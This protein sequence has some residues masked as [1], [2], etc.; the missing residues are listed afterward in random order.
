MGDPGL[1][2]GTSSLSEKHRSDG[3]SSSIMNTLHIDGF[4]EA[5][6]GW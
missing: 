5:G 6:V 4:G 3:Q 2:P 1:E